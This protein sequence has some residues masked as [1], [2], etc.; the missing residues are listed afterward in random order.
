M[1]RL[2]LYSL[3]L[4]LAIDRWWQLPALHPLSLVLSFLASVM[5]AFAVFN[6]YEAK[7]K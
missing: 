3:V 5:V 7:S 4:V 1:P 2:A 6:I